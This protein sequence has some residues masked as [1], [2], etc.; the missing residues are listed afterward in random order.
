MLHGFQYIPGRLCAARAL[1]HVPA[2]MQ[3]QIP[4]SWILCLQTQRSNTNTLRRTRLRR[5][6][7]ACKQ[8]MFQLSGMQF[9]Q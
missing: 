4:C 9:E 2:I 6:L 7:A 8:R 3:N 5:A 1:S